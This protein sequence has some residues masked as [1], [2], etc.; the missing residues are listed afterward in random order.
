MAELLALKVGIWELDSALYKPHICYILAT[1]VVL[2]WIMGPTMCSAVDG[3]TV[4]DICTHTFQTR[5][6]QDLQIYSQMEYLG[7]VAR[8][9]YRTIR[10]WGGEGGSHL[11]GVCS[12]RKFLCSRHNN[13]SVCIFPQ[14]VVLCT[15]SLLLNQYVVILYECHNNW[16]RQSFVIKYC[17]SFVTEKPCNPI[18]VAASVYSNT[19]AHNFP[20]TIQIFSYCITCSNCWLQ[21]SRLPLLSEIFFC[22]QQSEYA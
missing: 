16:N 4:G 22:L 12:Y 15:G 6:I 19:H 3:V 13:S 7:R 21:T 14:L 18:H 11:V 10:T 8:S 9:M 17:F 20:K 1:I 2:K 5:A